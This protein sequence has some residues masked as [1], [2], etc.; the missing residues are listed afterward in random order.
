MLERARC[1]AVNDHEPGL[2]FLVAQDLKTFVAEFLPA[3]NLDT[4][5]QLAARLQD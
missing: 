3:H 2:R 5:E 4:L 1:L